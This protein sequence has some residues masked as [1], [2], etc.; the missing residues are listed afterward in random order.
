[1]AILN[2]LLIL[3][4]MSIFISCSNENPCETP[5]EGDHF[6]ISEQTK[7]Y[8]SNYEDQEKVI[9]VNELGEEIQFELSTREEFISDYSF[10][11]LCDTDSNQTQSVRG[12]SQFIQL[13]IVNLNEIPDSIYIA[14]TELP[15]PPNNID[16]PESVIVTCGK[17][18]LGEIEDVNNLLWISN[19]NSDNN[20]LLDTLEIFDKIFTE[21]YEPKDMSPTPKLD[22]KYTMN[23]GVIYIRNKANNK[24]YVYDRT[25]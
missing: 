17:W 10:G 22:I 12:T 25:E 13:A 3:V 4:L 18:L 20:I 16:V 21:V 14:L 6:T 23:Q 7:S 24:E 11:E 2:K 19:K 9:F 8:L 15:I 5:R 1:M